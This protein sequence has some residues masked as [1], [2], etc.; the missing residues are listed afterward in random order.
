MLEAFKNISPLYRVLIIVALSLLLIWSVVVGYR[1]LSNSYDV[2]VDNKKDAQLAQ[3]DKELEAIKEA[4]KKEIELYKADNIKLKAERDAQDKYI[5]TIKD[6]IA[7][8]GKIVVA[9]QK[10]ID[11]ARKKYEDTKDS[12]ATA[13]DADTYTQCVCAKLGVTCD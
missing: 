13:T 3:K 1:K 11:E 5:A 9:E 6:A 8:D 7:N 10:K 2:Y 12:C 4:N